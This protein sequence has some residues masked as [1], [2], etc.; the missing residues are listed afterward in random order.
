METKKCCTC[1]FIHYNGLQVLS[2]FDGLLSM[3]K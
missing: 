1:V 3:L 2:T